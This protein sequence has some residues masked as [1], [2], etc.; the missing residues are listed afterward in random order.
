MRMLLSILAALVLVLAVPALA[1][2]WNEMGDA[3]DLPG[4]AQLTNCSGALT[5]IVGAL[6]ASDVDMY[7]I[8]IVDPASFSATTCGGTTA[9]T[10]IFLFDL[11]GLGVTYD[12]DDPGGCGLQSTITGAFVPGPEQYYL[13]VS[14]YNGDPV[15]SAGQ[16]LWLNTPYNVERVPD[17]PGAANPIAGWTTVSTST[18]TYTIALTG[19]A[20]CGPVAVEETTWGAVKGLYR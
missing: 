5:S 13:A 3:G 2:T 18:A 20:C 14:R 11:A 8:T 10:Q 9:D 15:D 4:T 19:V 16:L 17:G 6:A 12:D 7:C 1:Q